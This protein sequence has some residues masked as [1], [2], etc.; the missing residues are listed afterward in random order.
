MPRL[1]DGDLGHGWV[2]LLRAGENV[3]TVLELERLGDVL[4]PRDRPE[5]G[6]QEEYVEE[7]G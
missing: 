4:E 5:L 2:E 1:V 6:P 7:F 3:V